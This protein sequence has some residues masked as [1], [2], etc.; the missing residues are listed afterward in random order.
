VA[1]AAA[2]ANSLTEDSMRMCAVLVLLVLV[3]FGSST[4]LAHHSVSGEFDMSKT[5][6]LKG[7]ISR[8][9]WINPHIYVHV[10]VSE[11]NGVKNTWRLETFPPSQMRRAGLTKELLM[12]KPGEVVTVSILPARD[13][14][15]HLGYIERITYED[16]HFNQLGSNEAEQLRR[17]GER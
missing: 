1:A 10:D 12:G 5:V 6:T 4:P 8:L 3:G 9:E 15:R 17:R 11:E 13:G 2:V 16:G 14:T 7:V